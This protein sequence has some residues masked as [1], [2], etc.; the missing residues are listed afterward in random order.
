VD[1]TDLDTEAAARAAL[2]EAQRRFL[3]VRQTA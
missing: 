1:L 2:A 3:E